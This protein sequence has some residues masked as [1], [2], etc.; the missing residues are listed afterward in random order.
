MPKMDP[1]C[2]SARV[3]LRPR[4]QEMMRGNTSFDNYM[5]ALSMMRTGTGEETDAENGS[6][7]LLSPRVASPTFSG[8]DA[9]QYL[10]FPAPPPAVL[11]SPIVDVMPMQ[12]MPANVMSPD[13]MLR[14]YAEQRAMNVG[15]P[16]Y[17][18]PVAGGAPTTM[19]TLYSPAASSTV[20][21]VPVGSNNPFRMSMM[22][23]EMRTDN[24]EHNEDAYGGAI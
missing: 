19:R 13:E 24:G 20:F 11:K 3:L 6:D 8:D 12:P 2:C 9:G 14:A 4:S 23:P 18:A 1:I 22:T 17:P 7:M 15:T 5:P 16:T 10:A 21:T